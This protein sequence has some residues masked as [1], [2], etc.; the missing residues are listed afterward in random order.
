MKIREFPGTPSP[1][2]TIFLEMM[3]REAEEKALR[4]T[5]AF[6]SYERADESEVEAGSRSDMSRHAA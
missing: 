3:C 6:F 2:L 4:N 1:C 5:S